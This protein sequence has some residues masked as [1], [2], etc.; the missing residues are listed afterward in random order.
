MKEFQLL[1]K[2]NITVHRGLRQIGGCITE[3]STA[4][5][6][7]FIDMGQNLPGMGEPTTPEQD[8]K[9]VSD[10]FERNKRENEAV[11]YSH[12]HEDHIGLFWAVPQDVPQYLGEDSKAMFKAKHELI[13]M[14]KQDSKEE[15]KLLIIIDKM[16]TWPRPEIRCN[17]TPLHVGDI[18]VTPYYCSHSTHDSHMFLIEADGKRIWHTGDFR[19]H[20]FLGERLY[21]ML[22]TYATGIDTLI[23]EGTMLNREDK[24]ITEAEVSLKMAHVMRAFKHVF[25][26]VSATNI[27]R[28]E[29]IVKA[30]RQSRHKVYVASGY[31]RNTME[32]F[33]KEGERNK[34]YKCFTQRPGYA[35]LPDYVP[36]GDFVIAVGTGKLDDVRKTL[37]KLD[38]AE[39]LLIYASWDGYYK[40]PEQVAANPK[41]KEFRELFSNVVDIHTSGHADRDALARVISLI[42]PKEAIIG[43]HKDEGTSLKDL[44]ISENLKMIVR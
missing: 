42:N 9:M 39:T 24:C 10:L 12:I 31:L 17:P 37:P 7:V 4:T 18:T 2:M 15:E 34:M 41:Y 38:P 40:D 35:K 23:I 36:Q 43:I 22:E 29:S 26:L 6:R 1:H 11:F 44:E 8:R 19:T 16:H 27:E 21:K 33:G 13:K 14:S 3:I 28:L 25:V 32:I 30:A 5:S 20:S